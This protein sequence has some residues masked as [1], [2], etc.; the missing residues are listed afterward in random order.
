MP[1]SHR[2]VEI[3][4]GGRVVRAPLMEVIWAEESLGSG[5][6]FHG[7][8]GE[9]IKTDERQTTQ[10]IYIYGPKRGTREGTPRGKGEDAKERSDKEKTFNS[11]KDQKN[12]SQP[13][14]VLP[15]IVNLLT[16]LPKS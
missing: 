16:G 14:E 3:W 7:E 9:A 2:D 5:R 15:H 6:H 8:Q 13:L 12:R 1:E 4:E 10:S 11:A